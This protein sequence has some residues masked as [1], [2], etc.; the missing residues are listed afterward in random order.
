MPPPVAPTAPAP[1]PAKP[2]VP[3]VADL[4]HTA[5][6]DYMAAK[7]V[8]ATSE[9]SQVIRYYPDSPQAGSAYYYLGEIDYKLGK[10]ANAVKDYDHVLDQFPDNEHVPVSHLHKAQALLILQQRDAGI[11]ELRALIT[12]FPLTPEASQARARLSGMHVPVVPKKPS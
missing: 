5:L 10:F 1:V 2:S 9:L 3:P 4:F 8:L 6:S 12:R 11:A 7:N